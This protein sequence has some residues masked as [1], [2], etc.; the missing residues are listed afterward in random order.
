MLRISFNGSK[1]PVKAAVDAGYVAEL[2]KVKTANSTEYVRKAKVYIKLNDDA[3][4]RYLA[5]EITI[6]K[7][8]TIE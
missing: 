6:G 3:L 8:I 1:D 4:G 7:V 2:D 5:R